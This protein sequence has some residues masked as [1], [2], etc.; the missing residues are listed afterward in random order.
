MA[1]ALAASILLAMTLFPI[2]G[3]LTPSSKHDAISL[4]AQASAAEARFFAAD[5]VVSRIS[6]IVVE[7]VADAALAAVRWLPLVSIGADGK[8]RYHQLKLGDDPKEG[9]TIRDESWYDPATQR[10]AHVLTLKG[11]PMF[12]NSYDGRSV[13]LL[14][15]DERGHAQLRD[16]SVTPAFQPPQDPAEF[17]GI[18]AVSLSASEKDRSAGPTWSAMKVPIKLADGAPA[19]TLRVA[20]LE[21]NPNVGLDAYSA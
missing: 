5:D 13:H 6:E 18:L 9:C 15:I 4:L 14:E 21:G 10:F 2:P 8:P 7:P 16:E 19:R 1:L 17:L 3:G 11:R 12:A 20:F